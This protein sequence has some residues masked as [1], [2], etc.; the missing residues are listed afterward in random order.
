MPPKRGGFLNEYPGWYAELRDHLAYLKIPT[1]VVDSLLG[2]WDPRFGPPRGEGNYSRTGSR[3]G[4]LDSPSLWGRCVN[5]GSP[6][7][8]AAP[9]RVQRGVTA[10]GAAGAIAE[11]GE[12]ISM[13]SGGCDAR[14]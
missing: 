8:L 12:R 14:S 11:R 6:W 4:C 5:R 10:L 13:E 3:K 9:S 2:S 1:G 7:L